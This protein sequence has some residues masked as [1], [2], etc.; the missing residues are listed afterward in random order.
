LPPQ[1]KKSNS[2]ALVGDGHNSALVEFAGERRK[3]SHYPI[4]DRVRQN[5]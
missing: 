3:R 5:V 1:W 2:A 4:P